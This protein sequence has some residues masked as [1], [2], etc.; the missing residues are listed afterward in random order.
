MLLYWYYGSLYKVHKELCL[1]VYV[2]YL[3]DHLVG[4]SENLY[5]EGVRTESYA[6]WS[7]VIPVYKKL[8]FTLWNS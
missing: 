1:S 7:V 5:W 2:S 6:Y 8:S 3:Q 4:P